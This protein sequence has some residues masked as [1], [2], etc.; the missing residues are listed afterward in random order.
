MTSHQSTLFI[1]RLSILCVFLLTACGGGGGGE[2]TKP[3]NG[4]TDNSG[5]AGGASGGTNGGTGSGTGG[6]TGG[7]GGSGSGSVTLAT[8]Q[9]ATLW[10]DTTTW[11]GA[12]PPAGVAVIIPAGKQVIIDE[13]TPLL[14]ELTIEGEL[15]FKAGVT[16][17]LSADVIK[18]KAGGALRAGSATAPF[19]GLATITLRSTNIAGSA[20]GM[21]TRG[22]L[23]DSGGKLELFG[24]PPT[25]PWTKLNAHANAGSTSLTLEKAVDW[26]TGDQIVLAPTEWYGTPWVTQ[27]VHDASTATQKLSIASVSGATVNTTAGMNAFRWG[28]LQYATD[29]GMSLSRGTFTKPNANVP[30]T[31]DERA[32]VGNLSRNIVIQA[33]DDAAWRNSG[34]GAQVMVMDRSSSLQMDGVEMRRMGQQGII[35]R[36][37]IHWHLLSY[38]QGATTSSGDVVNHFMRNSTVADSKHRC[39]VIHG[40]NGVTLQNNIC[41]NIKGHAIFLEDA[42]EQRNVIEGNLVMRVRSPEDALSTT[43]HEKNAQTNF[44]GASAAY[45]LTNPNNTVRNNVA[46]DAQGNGFWLSYPQK[47]VKQGKN[48]PIRPFNMGHGSFENNSA[49]SNGNHGLMLECAM[50]DDAG[51]LELLSYS[52]TNDGS[53]FDY[54]NGVVPVLKRITS[55][56]NNGGYVNRV[57][58]PSYEEWMSADNLG[59]AFSGAVQYGSVLKHSLVIGTSLNNRQAYPNYADPQ[60]AVASYHSQMNITQNVFMNF[61]NVGSLVNSGDRDMASGVFG[62]DDYYI[63]PVEKGFKRNPSNILINADAGFRAKPPHLQAGY[64]PADKNNW[65]LSGAIWDPE[66][67]WTT[68][69]SYWVLDSPFLKAPDCTPIAS[70]VPTN[71]ANG[72]SCA[73]P[74]YGVHDFRLGRDN[75]LTFTDQYSFNETLEATRLDANGVALGTWRVENGF[76]SNMLGNMRHFAAMNGGIYTVRFPEYPHGSTTKVSPKWVNLAIENMIAAGGSFILGVQ[77][78]GLVTPKTVHLSPGGNGG[79]DASH[80]RVMTSV[81]SRA[82]VASGDGTKFWQDK[83]NNIIWVKITPYTGNFWTGV[84][85]NSDD[86]L[87]RVM[88]LRIQE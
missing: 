68:K 51:N 6:T 79:F 7:S 2:T 66:G 13:N 63:R 9:P 38:A 74:Y 26:K 59:R 19:T 25:V 20:I 46:V 77:Y 48:V 86:D 29:N 45:W 71:V 10:S 72:L 32:E 67:Y 69:G 11:G 37:P 54:T 58:K 28:Q 73:G 47:P 40:T 84:V 61:K 24:K 35:G 33:P 4:A 87:Y 78:D 31:L 56:K 41:Y 83:T 16:A 62:T 50:T 60:L 22:I 1:K 23:V 3:A 53:A 42:T 70:K 64:T 44:C 17:E 27:A 85:P 8:I 65:T 52:P 43:A 12:K 5:S 34:F 14:G 39:M 30:D 88:A 81:T 76:D 57:I 49:R 21:G 15:L 82:L 55:A 80:T 18:I 75:P 36:Y